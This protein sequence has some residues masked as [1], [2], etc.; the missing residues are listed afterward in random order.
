[1]V[2]LFLFF[3]LL[4][5]LLLS[6]PVFSNSYF[7]D[8][9]RVFLRHFLCIAAFAAA[10]VPVRIAYADYPD[11]LARTAKAQALS[12]DIIWHRLMHYQ[13]NKI[14]PGVHSL[15]DDQKYFF[16][17]D[18]VTNPAS[19][20]DA[21]IRAFFSDV[22]DTEET[23]H[24]QCMFP[25]RFAWLDGKLH[26]D[27]TRLKE[28][29]C[30]R[31]RQWRDALQTAGITLVYPAAYLNNPASMFGHT[32]FR[33]DAA[34]QDEST[35]LL[36]YGASYAANTDERSGLVF[37]V[38]G[39]FGGY[40]GLFSVAPYYKLVN[41]YSDLE[42]RDIWEYELVLSKE[43]EEQIVRHLWELGSADFDYYFFDENCSYH[44]LSLID[45][46]R[47]D[48]HLTD[49]FPLSAIPS[50]TVR[51]AAETPGLVSKKI[52]RPASTTLIKARA[53]ELDDEA[54]EKALRLALG[55][56]APEDS[57]LQEYSPVR[58]ARTLELGF[59]YLNYRR[60]TGAEP[61]EEAPKRGRD[62]LLARSKVGVDLEP[63]KVPMPKISP[64]QGHPTGR[65]SLNFGAED[66]QNYYEVEWRPAYHDLLDPPGGYVEGAEL[67][68]FDLA[69]RHY[70]GDNFELQR[71]RPISIL[72]LAPRDRFFKP[73]SW[74]VDPGIEREPHPGSPRGD[75]VYGVQ[76]GSGRTYRL[77]DE[78]L[79]LSGM[80]EGSAKVSESYGDRGVLGAGPMLYSLFQFNDWWGMSA[81]AY[82]LHFVGED[83]R[84]QG[85]EIEERWRLSERTAL[86][87]GLGHRRIFGD[88]R[89]EIDLRWQW[90]F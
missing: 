51:V 58:K 57:D 9:S 11:E 63:M 18:G 79:W 90:Y 13:A 62:L 20:M 89:N 48:L 28:Q 15:V 85:V 61:G 24:P 49:E 34:D 83:H 46:V 35:R 54:Q 21:T 76:G 12:E 47:P 82:S 5:P 53:A 72:S 59:E 86:R 26:F 87:F 40:K 50:D 44:L 37:A 77:F 1:M 14:L 66:G 68:F 45:V 74:H 36:A 71:F 22:P 6:V 3:F 69:F 64:D 30:E 65:A 7:R 29:P 41:R 60:L 2:L 80:I 75:L 88:S 19:E 25:A 73:S 39:I 38:R 67:R 27:R 81:R 32:L 31:F 42:N 78:R 70:E 4:P 17:A 10:L 8:F 84:D 43:E 16:A 33:L 52:Y 56:A 23:Q 55:E